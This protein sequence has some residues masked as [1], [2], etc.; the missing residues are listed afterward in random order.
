M[1]ICNSPTD[2]RLKLKVCPIMTQTIL[3]TR[4]PFSEDRGWSLLVYWKSFLLFLRIEKL[5]RH[6]LSLLSCVGLFSGKNYFSE[7]KY[8]NMSI[9]LLNIPWGTKTMKLESVY[10]INHII[11]FWMSMHLWVNPYSTPYAKYIFISRS[12]TIFSSLTDYSQT[13]LCLRG[14]NF[15][16]T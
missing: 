5:I 14:T 13:A 15:Y 3:T 1:K 16:N 12:V 7:Q 2:I 6:F 8:T 10:S 9:A 11:V 4:M